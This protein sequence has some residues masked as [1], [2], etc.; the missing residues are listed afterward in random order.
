MPKP[1]S[2]IMV[3]SIAAAVMLVGALLNWPYGYY[4]FLR[5]VVCL[6]AVF[7]AFSAYTI[8]KTWLAWAFV[9]VA[10]LFN[11]LVPIHLT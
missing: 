10:V 9:L 4:V 6:K 2:I 11:P 5:W 7:C 1:T 8:K 3:P